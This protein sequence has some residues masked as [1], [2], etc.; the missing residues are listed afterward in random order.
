MQ[1]DLERMLSR[2][3]QQRR[4]GQGNSQ[5]LVASHYCALVS[6]ASIAAQPAKPIAEKPMRNTDSEVVKGVEC[7]PQE[8]KAEGCRSWSR[9]KNSLGVVK[10]K[11]YSFS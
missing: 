8:G 4:Y 5:N 11:K 10:K 7:G 3:Q 1:P 2:G 6:L 9:M